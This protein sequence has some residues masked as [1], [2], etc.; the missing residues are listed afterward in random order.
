MGEVTL[1]LS[2][3]CPLHFH[4]LHII[5]ESGNERKYAASCL[6]TVHREYF[7]AESYNV[8]L[9]YLSYSNSIELYRTETGGLPLYAENI[10]D[11]VIYIYLA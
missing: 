5:D 10:G 11:D 4:S 9:E 6:I 2:N 7:W 3:Q 1:V 8:F